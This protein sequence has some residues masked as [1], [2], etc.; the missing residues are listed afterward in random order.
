MSPT[1]PLLTSDNI[2]YIKELCPPDNQCLPD[3]H[4]RDIR[5]IRPAIGDYMDPETTTLRCISNHNVNLNGLCH[6]NFSPCD[7]IDE[8]YS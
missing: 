6:L 2:K 3:S 5:L 1:R 7:V 8:H 4:I